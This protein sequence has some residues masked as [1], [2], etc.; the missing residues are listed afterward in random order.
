MALILDRITVRDFKRIETLELDLKPVTALVGG[1]TSGKSSALQA[2]QLGISVLQAAY[3]RTLADGR[4]DFLGT[5]SNDAVVFRPTANLLEL[6]RLFPCTQKLGYSVRYDCTDTDSGESRFVSLEVVRGKNA[7]VGI[8]IN[9]DLQLAAIL[10]DRN[11][12]FSILTPGLSGIPLREEWRTRGSMDAAVMHDD[13][14]MYLRTV[15]DHLFN[16]GLDVASRLAWNARQEI[17]ELPASG[18]KTFSTL[19]DRCYEGARLFVDHDPERQRYISVTVK[20]GDTEMPL[21]MASTGILQVI[22]ILAYA[23]FYRPP[24]LLLDEPDA[25]LHADSQGRLFEAL[26]GIADEDNTRILLAS[27]SPQ[28]IQRLMYDEQAEVVWMN[29][30]AKVEVDAARRPAIPILM[31]LGALTSGAEVFDPNRN[32]LLLTEDKLTDPVRRLVE[33]SGGANGLAVLSYNGCGNLQGA[34]LLARLITDMRDDVRVFIHRDRDF[35]TAV[36]LEFEKRV[37]TAFR[38]NEGMERVEE[39]FTSGNDVE[40]SFALPDHLKTAFPEIPADEVDQILAAQ[41]AILRDDL[42]EAARIARRKIEEE[43]YGSGR[44]R[45]KA[46]WADV[47]MPEAAPHLAGFL[48]ANGLAPVHFEMCHGK[49]LFKGLRQALHQRIGGDSKA[50]GTRLLSPTPALRNGEWADMFAAG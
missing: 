11:R 43:I 16:Q 39:I 47:G 46:A 20:L 24:L 15:L 49:M 41:I 8:V 23:C 40:H 21:D 42:V 10:A 12:P 9:G 38:E 32:L 1:N 22:Q 36:E 33:A 45:G 27:H 48:P 5:V 7:N 29:E 13:A 4:G 50:V 18:W 2:A 30:G 37:F 31:S 25:H 35:M 6:R 28:L 19:L 34:R 17:S 3:R 44:L 26:R 14:N